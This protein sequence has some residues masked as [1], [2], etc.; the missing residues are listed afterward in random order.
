MTPARTDELLRLADR[1]RNASQTKQY[2][3]GDDCALVIEASKALRACAHRSG[4]GERCPKCYRTDAEFK[5][6]VEGGKLIPCGD[7]WHS[8]DH[9]RAKS[10][11]APAPQ[12]EVQSGD[13][14]ALADKLAAA[15][16]DQMHEQWPTVVPIRLSETEREL[17]VNIIRRG[18]AQAG[19]DRDTVQA[20]YAAALEERCQRGTPWDLACTTIARK[21]LGLIGEAYRAP[22]DCPPR[23]SPPPSSSAQNSAECSPPVMADGGGGEAVPS[24]EG[25]SHD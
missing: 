22:V 5:A 6:T 4:V 10:R 9:L 19:L 8:D 14:L 11:A 12:C 20:C 24:A 21:L 18:V 15:P 25:N 2:W 23:N 1:L 17:A 7:P 13:A 16:L 3:S